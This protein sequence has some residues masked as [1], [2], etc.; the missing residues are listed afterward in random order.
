[1]SVQ[2]RYR[3]TRKRTG[4]SNLNVRQSRAES[5]RGDVFFA[6]SLGQTGQEELHNHDL[7][8][9]KYEVGVG[10]IRIRFFR[11]ILLLFVRASECAVLSAHDACFLRPGELRL[12]FPM[13][14]NTAGTCTLH[15]GTCLFQNVPQGMEL[16][17]LGT[18]PSLVT[19]PK[20]PLGPK[21]NERKPR[22][23]VAVTWARDDK[24]APF[25]PLVR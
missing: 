20:Q 16:D 5:G 3:R 19:S 9:G 13:Q 14:C 17:V 1:M 22:D 7:Q 2:C 10:A 24:R 15:L 6:P 12:R 11:S 4:D 21:R 8:P 23:D 18:R 25:L